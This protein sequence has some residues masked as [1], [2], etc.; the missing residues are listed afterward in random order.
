MLARQDFQVESS[1]LLLIHACTECR[2]C[3]VFQ[4]HKRPWLRTSN[5]DH[6]ESNMKAPCHKWFIYLITFTVRFLNSSPTF[7]MT[8]FRSGSTI[9]K[10]DRK[11]TASCGTVALQKDCIDMDK[12]K[13]RVRWD[14]MFH[15]WMVWRFKEGSNNDVTFRSPWVSIFV[16]VEQYESTCW[17]WVFLKSRWQL[18]VLDGPWGSTAKVETPSPSSLES[19]GKKHVDFRD[20][21]CRMADLDAVLGILGLVDAPPKTKEGSE[22]SSQPA[23]STPTAEEAPVGWTTKSIL[24]Q[25]DETSS[26]YFHICPWYLR[27]PKRKQTNNF[28]PPGDPSG[29]C[30]TFSEVRSGDRGEVVT[31]FSNLKMCIAYIMIIIKIYL[32]TKTFKEMYELCDSVWFSM[33]ILVVFMDMSKSFLTF[34]VPS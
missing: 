4:Q 34:L 2:Q 22:G 20:Q 29:R 15:S 3:R 13:R 31:N 26:W 18:M 28:S 1:W 11:T 14:S 21:T 27:K 24:P 23:L 19:A 32:L 5:C 7:S 25:I 16:Q 30:R 10:S 9:H 17:K 8:A 12:A 33:I 6:H